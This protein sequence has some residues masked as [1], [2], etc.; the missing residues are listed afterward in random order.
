MYPSFVKS[1]DAVTAVDWDVLAGNTNPFLRHAF[2]CTLE[3]T[4]CVTPKTGWFPQHLL[5]HSEGV[6]RGRLIGA[7]PMYLKNHSYGE[8]VFDWA[9][10]NAYE[11]AG[12][13]YYPKLVVGI[14]F[15]PVTGPRLLIAP[16]T[17]Q[18]TIKRHLIRAVLDRAKAAQVSSLHWLF[19]PSEDMAPLAEAGHMHR[20]G[21][22]FHWHNQGYDSF[23]QFLA[24]FA[25][26]KRKKIKQERRYVREA[27]VSIE[28]LRGEDIK[29]HHW[30][31][32]YQ[33]YL[34]TLHNY[35]AIPYLNR[36]FF[37]K[38]GALMAEDVLLIFAR[39]NDEYIAGALN[40]LGADALYGRYW[41]HRKYVNGL[42][43]EACYYAAM[44]Y[45]IEQRLKRFEAGAQG[46]HKIA[47]GFLPETTYSAH[48]LSHPE[49]GPAVADFLERE[50]HSVKYYMDELQEH[51]PFKKSV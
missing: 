41:G 27:G 35:R 36:S 26:A 14:P 18:G 23:D 5:L 2:L 39:Q 25:S 50:Q 43:F 33:F 24:E 13:R 30:D 16:D 3:T 49:F 12:L 20:T 29:T 21:Y 38:L 9:W 47:R 31:T 17:E 42:H 44:G 46:E 19:L 28:L 7:V 48:W 32:F 34:S 8:Y 1:I 40:L 11:H 4:G 51:S 6:G 45:C 15:T 10:A 22:Q 37:H